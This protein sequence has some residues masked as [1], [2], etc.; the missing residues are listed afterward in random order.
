MIIVDSLFFLSVVILAVPL[1]VISIELLITF[2]YLGKLSQKS[3]KAYLDCPEIKYKILIPAHN[4]SEIIADTL[5]SLLNQGVLA[6]DIVVVADNCSDLTADM[7]DEIG[8]TVLKRSDELK[9][10]KGYALQFGIDYLKTQSELDLDVVVVLDADCTLDKDSLGMLL[11]KCFKYNRP[12]QALYLMQNDISA[13]LK[14]RVAGFAWFV[15][16][17]IR[18]F[19]VDK[20]NLPVILTGTGMAFPWDV[21]ANVQIS[22]GNIVEDMQLGIDCT[23]M[24]SPPMFCAEAIVYSAFPEH[25]EAEM[26]QRIRW[27]HGHMLTIRTQVPQLFKQ[28]FVRKDWR[29]LFLALDIGVPPLA[30][31]VL[32]SISLLPAV[33]IYMILSDGMLAFNILLISFL[34]FSV[35]LVLIWSRFG[36]EYLSFKELFGIPRYIFSKLSVYSSFLFKRQTEWVR[37]SRKK[38]TD[39]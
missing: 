21:I 27:E 6:E 13:S 39:Q 30:L 5:L 20:L 37:T 15:K 23:L 3:S 10:G 35:M 7:A 18:P 26:T 24:G 25:E 1:W 17:K 36:R 9:R 28:A 34:L 2:L 29:L 19:A 38:K 16:N 8:V 14:R 31:L 22:D 4:E 33:V 32:L 12:Q 11:E